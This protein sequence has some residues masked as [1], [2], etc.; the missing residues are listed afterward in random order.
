MSSTDSDDDGN[1]ADL[2]WQL[3]LAKDIGAIKEGVGGLKTQTS[4][5]DQKVGK[6]REEMVKRSDCQ[7]HMREV[8]DKVRQAMAEAQTATA[9]AEEA[10]EAAEE[11]AGKAEVT[12]RH[13]VAK[14]QGRTPSGM[15]HPAVS[16]SYH[17]PGTAPAVAPPVPELTRWERL[18]KQ[19]QGLSTVITFVV[20]VGGMLFALA[21]FVSRV[22]HALKHADEQQQ[23]TTA[24]INRLTAQ[25]GPDASTQKAP[26]K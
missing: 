3:S 22:E 14:L 15:A 10:S 11:A 7:A 12:A 20:L 2:K 9:T 13:E 21:H 6:I 19:A 18:V 17:A 4:C 5:L 1:G 25:P 8:E 26:A 16:A 24:A 23:Q